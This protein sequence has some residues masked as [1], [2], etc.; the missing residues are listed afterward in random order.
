MRTPLLALLSLF[1]ALLAPA[2][3][4]AQSSPP[5]VVE[6]RDGSFLRGTIVERIEGQYVVLQLVTGEVRRYEMATVVYAGPAS[7]RPGEVQVPPPPQTQLIMAAPAQPRGV[8]VT[9]VPARSD[10]RLTAHRLPGTAT[11]AVWTG[12]GVG[13]LHID[14]FAPL[15]TAP[16][17]GELEP[18]SYYFG[19]SEND[20][21]A[22]R[23]GGGPYTIT[24][25]TTLE[26]DYDNRTGLRVAGWITWIAGILGGTLLMTIPLLGSGNLEAGPLIG[27]AVVF[28]VGLA[29]GLPLAFLNDSPQVRVSPR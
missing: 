20:G 29:V 21:N 4:G 6:L 25:P 5:D 24:G 1:A 3:V 28:T 23:A 22:Q 18:G 12:R 16:C 15:C 27:G 9:I 13:T 19:V 14:S 7:A 2:P 8:P 11:A 17:E 26:I 10:A